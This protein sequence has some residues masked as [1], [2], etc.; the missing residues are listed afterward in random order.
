MQGKC[1]EVHP[2]QS[3]LCTS[4]KCG[5]GD[6]NYC[7]PECWDRELIPA[8]LE[9]I[10]IVH[11]HS[12]RG[13]GDFDREIRTVQG[14]KGKRMEGGWDSSPAFMILRRGQGTLK[15]GFCRIL[16][17]GWLGH[18]LFWFRENAG[19]SFYLENISQASNVFGV[20]MDFIPVGV[21][22]YSYSVGRWCLRPGRL[23]SQ[24]KQTS[25]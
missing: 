13:L 6:I 17:S 8:C 19:I 25:L 9:V 5:L 1:V 7:L 12:N 11:F 24:W 18:H 15:S 22:R 20:I 16:I 10:I 2:A 4:K 21:R 23:A 3:M 14:W